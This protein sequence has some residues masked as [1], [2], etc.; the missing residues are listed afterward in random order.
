MS[1]EQLLKRL[2]GVETKEKKEKK[3][4]SRVC[5]YTNIDFDFGT[6]AHIE[7]C[8][9]KLLDLVCTYDICGLHR[10]FK[11]SKPL[12]IEHPLGMK[13]KAKDRLYPPKD[14]DDFEYDLVTAVYELGGHGPA[15]HALI[16]S[17]SPLLISRQCSRMYGRDIGRRGYISLGDFRNPNYHCSST[18]PPRCLLQ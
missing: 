15:F 11:T 9:G 8:G 16:M 4:T 3:E 12:N 10:I 14:Y 18:Y 7:E 13:Q 2:E 5:P 6:F 1:H 17:H